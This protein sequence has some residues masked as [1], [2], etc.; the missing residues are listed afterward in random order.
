MRALLLC[1]AAACAAITNE[2]LVD[3]VAKEMAL[4]DEKRYR[5]NY[6]PRTPKELAEDERWF[7]ADTGSSVDAIDVEEHAPESCARNCS[8]APELLGRDCMRWKGCEQR[9]GCS[10]NSH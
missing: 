2:R 9:K 1:A 6:A 10:S 5:E 4:A 8:I 3:P 7:L